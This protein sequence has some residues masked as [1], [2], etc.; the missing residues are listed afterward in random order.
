MVVARLW[1][2]KDSI[3][4][5]RVQPEASATLNQQFLNSNIFDKNCHFWPHMLILFND[6]F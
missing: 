5:L 1:N 6:D 3:P 2:I 4:S